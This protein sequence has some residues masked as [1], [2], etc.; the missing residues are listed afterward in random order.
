V[1]TRHCCQIKVRASD[2]VRRRASRWRRGGEIAGWI[3]PT[4]TLALLPKC[5]VCVAAYVTLATGVG[6]SLP[7]ATYLRM[8]LVV[9]CV[10]SLVFIAARRLGSFIS[11]GANRQ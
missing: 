6:I 1:N 4:A 7:T 10:A 2:N 5:P 9:L 3:I 11:R 8:M